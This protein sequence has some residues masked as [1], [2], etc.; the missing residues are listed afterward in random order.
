MKVPLTLASLLLLASGCQFSPYHLQN[1]SSTSNPVPFEGCSIFP[2]E[3]IKITAGNPSPL[4]WDVLATTTSPA[5]LS[6][7]DANKYNWYCW[8]ANVTIPA[9]Y[10]WQSGGHYATAV[11]VFDSNAPVYTYKNDPSQCTQP[12]GTPM[13]TDSAPCALAPQHS[14]N[15]VPG[16]PS[17]DFFAGSILIT[18]SSK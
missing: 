7:T 15:A 6:Y 13:M 10:W 1:F 5:K 8:S 14:G 18:A 9:K 4:N 12:Y 11:K 17:T 2:N 16:A 3:E